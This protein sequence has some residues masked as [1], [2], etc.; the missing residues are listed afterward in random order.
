MINVISNSFAAY[1]GNKLN[2][3]QENIEV[4]AY[5]LKI[6]LGVTLKT[7]C[8]LGLAWALNVLDT[9]LLVLAVFA[10]FR[11]FGGGAHLSNY[12][13]CLIFGITLIVGLGH[14]SNLYLS[15]LNLGIL[16]I[17]TFV[18]TVYTCIKIAPAGTEKKQITDETIR[19]RQKRKLLLIIIL[20]SCFVIYLLRINQNIYALAMILGGLSSLLL[21][22]PLG[23]KL[24]AIIDKFADAKGG[25]KSV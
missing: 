23:Y 18:L 7:V 3:S 13:R 8:I 11:C 10:A 24:L 9:T 6:A 17:L 1:L 20:W 15:T 5:G 19:L 2:S 4:Y 25:E 22:T 21:I 16:F 12:T 14:L